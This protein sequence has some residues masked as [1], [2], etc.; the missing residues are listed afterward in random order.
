MWLFKKKTPSIFALFSSLVSNAVTTLGF[1]CAKGHKK[2]NEN[3][4]SMQCTS[5]LGFTCA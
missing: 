4:T 2:C 5:T 1:T 3:I